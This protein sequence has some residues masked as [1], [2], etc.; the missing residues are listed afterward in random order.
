MDGTPLVVDADAVRRHRLRAGH[1]DRRLPRTADGLRRAAWAGAQDSMPRAALL[2]LHARLADVDADVLDDPALVQI[3]GPRHNLYVV[4]A[5][6]LW[7]F[8][9]GRLPTDSRGRRRAEDTARRARSVLEDLG[10]VPFATIGRALGIDPNALRYA[11]PTG[12]LLVR[13]D[14]ARQPTVRLAPP[15]E[16]D[17]REARH[18]LVRRY[19]HVYGPTPPERFGRWAAVGVRQAR[20]TF[21]EL[22][23]DLVRV[24]TPIGEGWALAADE[25]SLRAP[26]DGEVDGVRLLPSGDAHWLLHGADR[27]LLVD[28]PALRDR[29]WTPRVWPGALLVDGRVAGT[30]RRARTTLDVE[31]WRPLTDAEREATGAAAAALP[32]PDA[33]AIS[34]RWSA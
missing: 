8:T 6:D 30:W 14:G 18:E 3:W 17:E 10:E 12:T 25:A 11:A 21:G 34:V 24:T 15:P 28:D 16:G 20:T 1:L 2:S 32:L 7:V 4:A 5:A 22:S 27:E 29:L 26:A 13:W 23:P 19:L 33:G 31:P 9:L